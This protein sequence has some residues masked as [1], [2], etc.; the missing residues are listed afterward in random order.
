MSPI[1]E[2]IPSTGSDSV[3]AMCQQLSHGLSLLSSSDDFGSLPPLPT[4]NSVSKN[5]FSNTIQ[6][7]G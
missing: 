5:L 6:A 7:Q 4:L 3:S 2:L 1:P